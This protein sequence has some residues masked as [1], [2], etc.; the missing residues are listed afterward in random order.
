LAAQASWLV[1][2][3]VGLGARLPGVLSARYGRSM[4]VA[5]PPRSAV[6]ARLQVG[7][8]VCRLLARARAAS[9]WE[10]P[11]PGRRASS[12]ARIAGSVRRWRVGVRLFDRLKTGEL[13]D[14]FGGGSTCLRAFVAHGWRESPLVA[15]A[16]RSYRNN[17]WRPTPTRSFEMVAMTECRCGVATVVGD[18]I[19][20]HHHGDPLGGH[21]R[22][23]GRRSRPRPSGLGAAGERPWEHGSV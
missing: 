15:S 1:P 8:R 20:C 19:R 11:C 22:H 16:A 10:P 5:P 21:P 23:D 12:A 17:T 13:I 14:V 6:R 2:A 7:E 4:R 3:T 9:C 18:R